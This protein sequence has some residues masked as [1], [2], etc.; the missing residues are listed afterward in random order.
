MTLQLKFSE[1][2]FKRL[3]RFKKC[4]YTLTVYKKPEYIYLSTD[5]DIVLR[6]IK[7]SD[8]IPNKYNIYSILDNN[9]GMKGKY[10][11]PTYY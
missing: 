8:I 5:L 6:T 1:D 3:E 7:K 11:I 10:L 2:L 4:G 9:L